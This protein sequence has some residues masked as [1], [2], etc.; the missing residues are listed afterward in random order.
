MQKEQ[1]HT[2]ELVNRLTTVVRSPTAEKRK[3]I[4]S[5][6]PS[7]YESTKMTGVKMVDSGIKVIV[8]A[9]SDDEKRVGAEVSEKVAQSPSSS[10]YENCEE[11][12]NLSC[13]DEPAEAEVRSLCACP[14]HLPEPSQIRTPD[15]SHTC[16]AGAVEGGGGGA[17]GAH[18]D[19][20]KETVRGP[21]EAAQGARNPNFL[22]AEKTPCN[23]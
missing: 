15:F 9:L 18:R 22:C 19:G 21:R 2:Q 12:E 1:S 17:F 11:E 13:S 10:G 20:A 23:F 16:H 7:S 3:S 14:S 6:R 8:R 5:P 4:E